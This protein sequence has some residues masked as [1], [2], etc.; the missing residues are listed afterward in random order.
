[1][2]RAARRDTLEGDIVQALRSVGA[3]VTRINEAGAPDLLVGFRGVTYCLECKTPKRKDGKAQTR[4]SGTELTPAQVRWRESWRGGPAV[5][6][7]SMTD[8]LQAVGG[9]VS[10]VATVR[11]PCETCP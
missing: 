9:M 3:S 4:A 2:R 6:V 1:M 8:A 5:V 10:P 11:A 7:R